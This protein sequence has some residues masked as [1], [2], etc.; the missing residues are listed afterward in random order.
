MSPYRQSEA[1]PIEPRRRVRVTRDVPI[2]LHI[3]TGSVCGLAVGGL[4]DLACE[5][6]RF[7]GLIVAAAIVAF[8]LGC[9][10]LAT[11]C[12]LTYRTWAWEDEEGDDRG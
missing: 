3:V 2:W 9:G 8:G 7:R 4:I 11:T 6:A 10:A 12:T 1:P 5:V